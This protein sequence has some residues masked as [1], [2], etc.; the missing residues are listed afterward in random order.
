M[1][2]AIDVGNTTI[3]F[4]A[5]QGKKL[6]SSWK[7][8]T[9]SVFYKKA[10]KLPKNID[11][12]IISSVVP[13]V[14]P[15]IKKMVAQKYKIRPFVLG[16]NIK[17]PIKNLYR[18]PR[19]VGQDRLVDAVAVKELCG[20]PAIVIDF[21]TAITFDVIS[22][23]GGYPGGIIVPGI[24][25]SLNAL[26]EKAALLPKIKLSPPKG[27]IGRDT[28][29]SMRSGVFHGFG[30][31]CDGII[32]KLKAKYPGAIVIAT[33]GHAALMTKYSKLIRKV[34]PNLTL[35]GLRIIY[36]RSSKER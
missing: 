30:S 36:D 2:L 16:G 5:F 35:H 27:L 23:K 1:L 32:A 19:Q 20:Y 4:G 24:E 17:A 29:D 21:G 25:T 31:L 33:G 6:K 15:I 14:T 11:A 18:N 10:I 34:D 22:K 26:S 3:A 12:A 9:Q 8:S 13:K 28:V 7:I